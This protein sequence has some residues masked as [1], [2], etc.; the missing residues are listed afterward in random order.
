MNPILGE[1]KSIRP[2]I[3]TINGAA[4]RADCAAEDVE[5]GLNE[6]EP[7]EGAEPKEEG[8]DTE[9]SCGLCG[10]ES[11]IRGT[12]LVPTPYK[13][14]QDEVDD[15]YL[16]HFP[17]RS[18]CRHCIRG[19]GKE[20]THWKQ[21]GEDGTVPEFHMDYCFPGNEEDASE[22]LTVLVIRMRGSP[23]DDE[24]SSP[25]KIRRRFHRKKIRGIYKRMRT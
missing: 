7:E 10:E 6:T 9:P 17:F 3:K 13:P 19:R 24:H 22:K 14:S 4:N 12:V 21:S 8:G 5:K 15:H 25:I 1:H 18:W 11:G 20:A 23:H 2:V 16:T